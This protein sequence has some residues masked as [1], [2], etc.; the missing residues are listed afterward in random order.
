MIAEDDLL[1]LVAYIKAMGATT[2]QADDIRSA[3]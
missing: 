1:R 3:P 2:G